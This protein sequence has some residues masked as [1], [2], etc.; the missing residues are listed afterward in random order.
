MGKSAL[1][2]IAAVVTF[3][4]V[5][6]VVQA[7]RGLANRSEALRPTALVEHEA[8]TQKPSG[9]VA[10]RKGKATGAP[11]QTGKLVIGTAVAAGMGFLLLT[12][13][14]RQSAG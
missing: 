2:A 4:V 14:R 5:I 1:V 12:V 3:V 11:Y 6:F 7:S 10:F 9:F 8:N 13:V